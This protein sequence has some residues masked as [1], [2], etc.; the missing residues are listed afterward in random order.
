MTKNDKIE[1]ISCPVCGNPVEPFDICE[2]C[3]YQNSGYDE[4]SSEIRG[5]NKM[6]LDEA[7]KAYK[8][9]KPIE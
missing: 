1:M 3:G 4:Q 7:R 9:G 8:E 6:T 2:K 5:P